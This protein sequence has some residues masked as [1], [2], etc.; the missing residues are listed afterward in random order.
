MK[1]LRIIYSLI[2]FFCFSTTHWALATSVNTL[3]GG[4]LDKCKIFTTPFSMS[5]GDSAYGSVEFREGVLFNATSLWTT[6]T[7]SISLPLCKSMTF[8]GG[9]WGAYYGIRI[10]LQHDLHLDGRNGNFLIDLT[11]LYPGPASVANYAYILGDDNATGK[12]PTIYLD[13]DVTISGYRRYSGGLLFLENLIIDG[14]GHVMDFT[15]CIQGG[16]AATNC[17]FRN[18]ILKNVWNAFSR[19]A[20]VAFAIGGNFRPTFGGISDQ[21]ETIVAV[22]DNVNFIVRRNHQ[23]VFILN[24]YEHQGG[25]RIEIRNNVILGNYGEFWIYNPYGYALNLFKITNNANLIIENSSLGIPREHIS[26]SMP[27]WFESDLAQM[28]LDNSTFVYSNDRGFYAGAR[29]ITLTL[30]VGTVSVQGNSSFE[31]DGWFSANGHATLL[32]GDG[33]SPAGDLDIII[34]PGATLNLVATNTNGLVKLQNV[35]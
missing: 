10:F 14:Q 23:F 29:D 3:S 5:A 17:T 16:V 24:G 19:D 12:Q 27:I 15:H 30:S 8:S 33:V 32:L 26:G 25:S 35:H 1:S 9:S 31:A 4:D 21:M 18:V 28:T 13:S 7:L 6:N 22:F 34:E 20:S 2:C 11:N